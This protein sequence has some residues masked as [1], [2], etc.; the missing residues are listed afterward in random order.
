MPADNFQTEDVLD[1]TGCCEPTRAVLD[2]IVSTTIARP[3]NYPATLEEE[4]HPVDECERPNSA[5]SLPSPIPQVKLSA[6]ASLPLNGNQQS[7]IQ[8]Q[9]LSAVESSRQA[10]FEPEVHNLTGSPSQLTS[11]RLRLVKKQRVTEPINTLEEIMKPLED[12]ERRLFKGFVELESE[13]VSYVHSNCWC[14]KLKN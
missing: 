11:S 14:L 9:T 5:R 8:P 1:A 3:I 4:G 12:A 13:P 2:N 6:H 7:H 10:N